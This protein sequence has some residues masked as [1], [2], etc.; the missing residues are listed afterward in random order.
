M[1]KTL[2]HLGWLTLRNLEAVFKKN[3]SISTGNLCIIVEHHTGCFSHLS[4]QEVLAFP[5]RVLDVKHLSPHQFSPNLHGKKTAKEKRS[6]SLKV[7][8]LPSSDWSF[9][10]FWVST[11]WKTNKNVTLR[12]IHCD[13]LVS[14]QSG[15]I[16]K[17]TCLFEVNTHWYIRLPQVTKRGSVF[18][19]LDE[20]AD[21]RV[22]FGR[23][24]SNQKEVWRLGKHRYA[25]DISHVYNSK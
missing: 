11:F 19:W 9:Q 24:T 20:T 5:H 4:P 15:C 2:H 12:W 23:P 22:C 16:R 7:G 25:V 3:I 14:C 8:N 6:P 10:F 21:S 18:V 1:D 17:A 13:H